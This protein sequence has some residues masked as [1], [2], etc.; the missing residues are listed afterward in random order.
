LKGAFNPNKSN[1]FGF[2][3]GREEMAYTGPLAEVIVNKNPG[4]GTYQLPR[5]LSNST[6]SLTGKPNYNEDRE[7][8]KVPGPGTYPPAFCIN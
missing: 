7:K 3:K 4:P 2:G 8:S 1:G 5:T 6:F